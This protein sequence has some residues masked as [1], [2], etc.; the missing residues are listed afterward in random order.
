MDERGEHGQAA[1][2]LV[3]LLPCVAAVLAIA[4]QLVLAGHAAW[5]AQ[6]AARAGA[7]AAAVGAD[8]GGRGPPP[9]SAEARA[10]PAREP[11]SRRRAWRSSVRIPPVLPALHLGASAARA[12]FEPQVGAVTAARQ[13]GPGDRRARRPP[14]A[15]RRRRARRLHGARRRRPR[16]SRPARPPRRAPSPSSSRATPRPRRARPSRRPPTAARPSRSTA[17]ASPWRSAHASP[18][19]P[20]AWRPR[21]PPTPAR[22][23]RREPPSHH[24]PVRGGRR[25]RDAGAVAVSAAQRS[26]ALRDRAAGLFVAPREG[27]AVPGA[28]R[29]P[30]A[31][32]ATRGSPRIAAG[33]ASGRGGAGGALRRRERSP[34][35]LVASGRRRVAGQRPASRPATPAASRLA[36]RLAARGVAAA[37][38]GRLAWAVLHEPPAVAALALRRLHGAVEVPLVVAL[39]GPRADA[40]DART[41]RPG[42]GGRRRARPR[43][44]RWPGSRWPGSTGRARGLRAAGRRRPAC[45]RWRGSA[46]RERSRSRC[47]P[48]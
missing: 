24:P 45:S 6:A 38:R 42:A 47:A 5:A 19:S 29:R 34:A 4:W 27:V 30:H 8:P 21:S 22:S 20:P 1:T 18:C 14:P 25:P 3:A 44:G 39:T 10:R 9:P 41:R 33:G 13:P 32:R 37:P 15:A 17:T 11:P 40:L 26:T 2:E 12:H 23:R 48:R 16:P 43:T 7:R 35:A 28:G 31:L 46:G 36:A